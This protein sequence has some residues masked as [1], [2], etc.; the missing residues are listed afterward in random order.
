MRF[1]RTRCDV[2]ERQREREN[3]TALRSALFLDELSSSSHA[4]PREKTNEGSAHLVRLYNGKYDKWGVSFPT[5]LTEIFLFCVPEPTLSPSRV[6]TQKEEHAPEEDWT[7]DSFFGFFGPAFSRFFCVVTF[8]FTRAHTLQ[9]SR[10]HRRGHK[11]RGSPAEEEEEE[12]EETDPRRPEDEDDDDDDD[13]G[14]GDAR[15]QGLED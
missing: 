4:A 3:E 8:F 14:G 9:S 11:T 5:F 10:A 1:D 6:D 2:A 7:L 12:E 15:H 13:G